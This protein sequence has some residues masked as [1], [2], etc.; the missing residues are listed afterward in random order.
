M[1][2]W[3]IFFSLSIGSLPPLTAMLERFLQDSVALTVF[4]Q[5]Q[6]PVQERLGV[7]FCQ[8]SMRLIR[9]Y[10]YSSTD[11][12][13]TSLATQDSPQAKVRSSLL[14]H[15]DNP[16]FP[17]LWVLPPSLGLQAILMTLNRQFFC[18]SYHLRVINS[19]YFWSLKN[20]F[21]F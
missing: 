17:S 3:I 18:C 19:G 10:F 21:N 16:R 4:V 1:V 15:H 6:S 20:F 13:F 5:Y 9:R 7:I 8:K 11:P 14:R 12:S 2:V